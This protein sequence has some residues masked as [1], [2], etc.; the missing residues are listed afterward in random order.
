M[1]AENRG[2][3]F[4][5]NYRI[6]VLDADKFAQTEKLRDECSAF[7]DKIQSLSGV[8]KTLVD[9]VDQQSEAIETEKL[10]AVGKRNLA[11]AENDNRKRRLK[12][13]KAMLAEKQ[14]MLERLNGEY[15][16]L[17]KVKHEQDV[18]ISKLSDG[19]D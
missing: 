7:T 16:S 10:R 8:V 3:S 19:T 1:A 13:M 18:L 6:R 12:E 11:S 17:V 2:I 9:A 5:E 14:A 4:D 15:D